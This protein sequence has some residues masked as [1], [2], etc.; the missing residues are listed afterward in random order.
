MSGTAEAGAEITVDISG[1]IYNTTADSNGDWSVNTVSAPNT[2]TLNLDVNGSNSVSVTATDD[3]N[4]TTTRTQ[5]LV[6]D[7]TPPSVVKFEFDKPTLMKGETCGVT[8]EFDKAVSGFNSVVDI[9]AVKGSLDAQMQS[10][11]GNVTWTGTFTPSDNIQDVS[12]VLTLANSYTDLAGNPGV[13]KSASNSIDTRLPTLTSFTTD[14]ADNSY[15]KKDDD[16]QITAHMS[17]P[18]QQDSSISVTLDTE[19]GI[20]LTAASAGTTMV[21]TYTV[22]AGHTSPGLTVSSFTIVTVKDTMG[23]D[24]S[25]NFVV[26][27]GNDMFGGKTIVIDTTAPLINTLEL[28]GDSANGGR[29]GSG[30]I[31]TGKITFID[32][33][34]SL[35]LTKTAVVPAADDGLKI[36]F[37]ATDGQ[38]AK[39]VVVQSISG[40]QALWSLDTTGLNT[41]DSNLVG[42]LEDLKITDIELVNATIRDQALNDLDLASFSETTFSGLQID[43]T[44]PQV[45]DFY[46]E[47]QM[48]FPA[49][50]PFNE[51]SIHLVFTCNEDTDFNVE[52]IKVKREFLTYDKNK[53]TQTLYNDFL[54]D[55]NDAEVG[56]AQLN[57]SDISGAREDGTNGNMDGKPTY[58]FEY[59]FPAADAYNERITKYTFMVE[60]LKDRADPSNNLITQ[61]FTASHFINDKLKPTITIEQVGNAIDEDGNTFSDEIQFQYTISKNVNSADPFA[62]S[63]IKWK[64]RRINVKES[65]NPSSYKQRVGDIHDVNREASS[66]TF[67]YNPYMSGPHRLYIDASVIHDSVGKGNVAADFDFSYEK[68]KSDALKLTNILK[69]EAEYEALKGKTP[70]SAKKTDIASLMKKVKFSEKRE[71]RNI[72]ANLL[73]SDIGEDEKYVLVNRKDLDMPNLFL[74]EDVAIVKS[75]KTIDLRTQADISDNVGFYA[76]L[77]NDEFFEVILGN[78]NEIT[79]KRDDEHAD[80]TGEERYYVSTSLS[81]TKY[82]IYKNCQNWNNGDG[83]LVP[84]DVIGIDDRRFFIGSVG[85]GGSET[86]TGGDPYISPIYGKTYKLP[87]DE[88]IYRM[89]DNNCEHDRF[90]INVKMKKPSKEYA[91]A[92]N[93][94]IASVTPWA[95][96]HTNFFNENMSFMTHAFI[97]CGNQGMVYD[98]EKGCLI[99][100]TDN[101]DAVIEEMD[102]NRRTIEEYQDEER[103][104]RRVKFTSKTMGNFYVY[105]EKYEN[106]QIRSGLNVSQRADTSNFV[107]ALIRCSKPESI[108][109]NSLVSRDILSDEALKQYNSNTLSIEYF[110]N[111]AN[112]NKVLR[113]FK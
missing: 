30:Q 48:G 86:F 50:K 3:A 107:G 74:E 103:T 7:T 20:I 113:V 32:T 19:D 38:Y 98:L 89:Y 87:V 5:N 111:N 80:G 88:N 105:F 110:G 44:G 79:F 57:T 33:N 112:G 100:K 90:L 65:T 36:T 97:Q 84:D 101:C 21:G 60:N 37:N 66:G 63:D 1:A 85:D 77:D 108:Q 75:G 94:K 73:L 93:K 9:S 25:S 14:A 61:Y 40:L 53:D 6:I 55:P 52:N 34:G 8:L 17:E 31:I 99:D 47:E 13:T 26:P 68:T 72:L 62:T 45:I 106:P 24:M 54:L 29:L 64:T 78:D 102:A 82:T 15:H 23:N 39:T 28:T 16:I 70:L 69:D 22:K 51:D 92:L 42:G 35:T 59:E 2:G 56:Y 27:T 58:T 96:K 43:T 49:N 71:A 46:I 81:S 83:Y 67:K 41:P 95:N 10:N 4:N 76:P 11:D 109:V 104:T 18:I 91:A 12:G